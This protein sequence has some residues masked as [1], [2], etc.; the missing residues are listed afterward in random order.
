LSTF[1]NPI[2]RLIMESPALFW[3][4]MVTF[5]IVLVVAVVD[6]LKTRRSRMG[7]SAMGRVPFRSPPAN[8]R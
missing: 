7:E 3:L 8:A 4:M 2:R 1:A 6:L 5:G